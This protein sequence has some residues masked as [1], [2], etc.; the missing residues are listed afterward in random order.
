MPELLSRS[1]RVPR[2]QESVDSSEGPWWE[3][4]Q[5]GDGRAKAQGSRDS[6]K[7][8][9][10]GEA[11]DIG[12]VHEPV[13]ELSDFDLTGTNEEKHTPEPIL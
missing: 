1:I 5:Q 10:E 4:H 11:H 12:E 8:L 6:R 13:E 7:V 2:V 9:S 3:G